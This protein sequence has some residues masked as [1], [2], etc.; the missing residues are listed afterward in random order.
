MDE[1]LRSEAGGTATPP[2]Y[3]PNVTPNLSRERA[4]SRPRTASSRNLGVDQYSRDRAE[5]F[6]YEAGGTATPPEYDPNL[7]RERS[8]SFRNLSSQQQDET[9]A[10]L[11]D[12]NR[13]LLN[14]LDKAYADLDKQDVDHAKQSSSQATTIKRLESALEEALKNQ[15]KEQLERERLKLEGEFEEKGRVQKVQA[16]AEL[17][18]YKVQAEAEAEQQRS[19]HSRQL[20]ASLNEAEAK[21]EYAIAKL[22]AEQLAARR[23]A[24]T[25]IAKQCR[26]NKELSG[27]MRD[28]EAQLA[29]KATQNDELGYAL[30]QE[31]ARLLELERLKAVEQPASPKAP[32]AAGGDEM[33]VVEEL[34][35]AKLRYEE[36]S[37]VHE[38][39]EGEKD[40]L[41]EAK[42]RAEEEVVGLQLERRASAVDLTALQSQLSARSKTC[43]GMQAAEAKLQAEAKEAR[44]KQAAAEAKLQAHL[45]R[46]ASRSIPLRW[47]SI[48]LRPLF[49]TY[50][51]WGVVY[52]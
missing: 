17:Q 12:K 45:V 27:E 29:Q 26:R 50:A 36:L 14:E 15:N 22:E 33:L 39:L 13:G 11:Q 31:R 18:E 51:P 10:K 5:S 48:R 7:S 9:V 24:E 43:D 44:A 19:E 28:V 42:A 49:C 32:G 34:Q 6:R 21:H 4:G 16:E 38:T 1:S 46:V 8:E 40:K 23:D 25:E 52:V 37:R 35:T 47:G 3:D 41:R 20:D 2:E 30:E